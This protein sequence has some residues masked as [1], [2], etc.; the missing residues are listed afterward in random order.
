MLGLRSI[1]PR[2]ST[3][4]AR[5]ISRSGYEHRRG[6]V[7]ESIPTELD[8]LN[9]GKIL[10]ETLAM[11]EMLE[12]LCTDLLK[13]LPHEMREFDEVLERL[14]KVREFNQKLRERLVGM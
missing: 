7:S 3:G 1:P 8:K 4:M 12:K 13:S 5:S 10:Q 14:D 11:G 6:Q 9:K 2:T